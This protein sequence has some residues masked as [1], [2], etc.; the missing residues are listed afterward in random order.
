MEKVE[1]ELS[2]LNPGTPIENVWSEYRKIRKKAH[3]LYKNSVSD[4]FFT[5]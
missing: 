1:M 3:Q 5:A 2:V 4:L